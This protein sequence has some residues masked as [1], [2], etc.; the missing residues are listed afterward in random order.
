[1][2]IIE[3]YQE[4]I[5]NLREGSYRITYRRFADEPKP[6]VRIV[7]VEKRPV[8]EL[9][10]D[11]LL[12]V[13]EGGMADKPEVFRNRVDFEA[14]FLATPEQ[15]AEAKR[16]LTN[17]FTAE[18]LET[19]LRAFAFGSQVPHKI[20]YLQHKAKCATSLIQPI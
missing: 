10:G 18:E 17:R 3:N 20:G 13:F 7:W 16:V 6:V 14:E 9:N 19:L 8:R 4:W 11:Q 12:F 5:K 2:S 1:M 15:D